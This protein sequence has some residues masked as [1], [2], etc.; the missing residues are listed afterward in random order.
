VYKSKRC[1]YFWV[2]LQCVKYLNRLEP[3]CDKVWD[4]YLL[5]RR[6]MYCY[7]YVT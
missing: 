2:Q 3:K 5:V 7:V 4:E 1:I 6:Q